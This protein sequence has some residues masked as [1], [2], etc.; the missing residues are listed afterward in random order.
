MSRAKVIEP[1]DKLRKATINLLRSDPFFASIVLSHDWREQQG[2]GFQIDGKTI[3]YGTQFVEDKTVTEL[4]YVLRHNVMHVVLG[5]HLR[6][7]GYVNYEMIQEGEA[8]ER[9][10]QRLNIAGDLAVNSLISGSPGRPDGCIVPGMGEHGDMPKDEAMEQYYKLLKDREEEDQEELDTARKLAEEQKDDWEDD[11]ESSE[12]N[13]EGSEPSASPTDGPSTQG[14]EGASEGDS[15]R[16]SPENEQQN[17]PPSPPNYGGT[18]SFAQVQEGEGQEGETEQWRQMVTQAEVAA[19]NAGKLPGW[20]K[21]LV[22]GKLE[23]TAIP[24]ERV[25]RRFLT[26]TIRS[27]ASYRRPNR[28]HGYRRDIILPGRHGKGLG[29]IV[30]GVDTSASMSK[31]VLNKALGELQAIAALY[32][33]SEVVVV[34]WDTRVVDETTYTRADFPIDT[35]KWEWRGRGGTAVL[36]FIMACNHINPTAVICCTDGLFP[37]PQERIQVPTLW[38][39]T[40]DFTPPWGEGLLAPN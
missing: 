29:K 20:L 11:E 19:D 16:E 7:E 17:G 35:S 9:V 36:E 30:F 33:E 38:I 12:E 28:R 14:P 4:E 39:K 13:T 6:H 10:M 21:E 8:A 1:I 3:L 40:R 27:H 24:W 34:Q 26:R 5:H 25:L 22:S 15:E 18:G 32:K 23:P 31:E 37:W 2:D